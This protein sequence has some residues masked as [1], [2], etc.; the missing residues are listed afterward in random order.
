MKFN[1]SKFHIFRVALQ[2]LDGL[3]FLHNS[4]IIFRDLKPDNVLIMSLEK[5]R[6]ATVK[7]VDFGIAVHS[8]PAG[9][10]ILLV[11]KSNDL[12]DKRIRLNL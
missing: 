10:L 3:A 5:H 2:I 7:L 4:R 9:K 8:I 1:S 12:L 6:P 11:P